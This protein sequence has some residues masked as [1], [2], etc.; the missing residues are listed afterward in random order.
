MDIIDC[1]LSTKHS[2]LNSTFY[3]ILLLRRVPSAEKDLE[4]ISEVNVTLSWNTL[5]SVF[6]NFNIMK[7]QALQTLS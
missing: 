4:L 2:F 3:C 7:S 5:K 6:S 1:N